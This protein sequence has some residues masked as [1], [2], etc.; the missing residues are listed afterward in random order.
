M[1]CVKGGFVLR[2]LFF[3]FGWGLL[4]VLVGF[5]DLRFFPCVYL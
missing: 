4:V 5:V 1:C 3:G 2:L